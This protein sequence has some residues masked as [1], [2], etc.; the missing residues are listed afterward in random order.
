M[1]AAADNAAMHTHVHTRLL[2]L[3]AAAIACAATV[4]AAGTGVTPP[5]GTSVVAGSNVVWTDPIWNDDGTGV[6]P[7]GNGDV[8]AGV[9]TPW[10][11]AVCG[12]RMRL[13]A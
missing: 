2:H 7:I 10:R 5:T 12:A 13:L 9:C 3:A 11:G 1:P 8:A 6:M 4:A